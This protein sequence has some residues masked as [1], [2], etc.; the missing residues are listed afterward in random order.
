MAEA[1]DVIVRLLAGETVTCKTDWF[2]MNEAR[3]QLS[4]YRGRPPHLAATS[5]VTPNG[6]VLAGH[7]GMGMLCVAAASEM[8]YSALDTNW[9]IACQSAIKA[10]R[11][12][13]RADLRLMAPFHVAETRQQAIDDMAWGF[14]KWSAYS[15][16]V[17][18]AGPAAIGLG[19]VDEMIAKHAAV[20][21]TPDDAVAQLE[22]YWE[23]TGGFGCM[24]ILGQNWASPEAT[25][26]SFDLI[27]RHVMPKFAGSNARR[28]ASYEWM[29]ANREAFSQANINAARLTIE[30]FASKAG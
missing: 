17:S 21:G 15:Y 5:T 6:A 28:T 14:E 26:R 8:G 2:E 4:G 23:K 20:I 7:H 24:L 11:T 16:Q 27:A 25:R 9:E 10:G 30:K 13:A 1:V 3:L 22:R 29:G 19:T 12:M 18:P